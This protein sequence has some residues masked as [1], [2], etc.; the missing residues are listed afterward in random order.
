MSESIGDYSRAF[1]DFPSEQPTLAQPCEQEDGAWEYIAP[2]SLT[3]R[4]TNAMTEFSLDAKYTQPEGTILL[5]GVQALVRLLLDQIRA[6]RARGLNTAGLVSGYRGSP[7]AGL[8]L[9]LARNQALL[10]AHNITFMPAVNEDLG[11]TAAFGSRIA[12]LLPAPRNDGVLGMWYGKAPGVDRSGDAFKHA[13]FA[14]VGPHGGVLAVAGDDAGAK[15]ST[16]PSHSEVALYDAMM[17]V[18]APGNVQEVLDLG[19]LGYELSRFCG[20]WVGFKFATNVA[21]EFA[22]AEVGPDRVAVARPE[23]A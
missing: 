12:N 2:P 11:A 16:L 6:D 14:G 19:R 23:F 4:H 22:S 15:S 7:L 21:D 17:P 20:L 1:A 3:R 5:S 10:D 13:N 18:L 9:P 8:D